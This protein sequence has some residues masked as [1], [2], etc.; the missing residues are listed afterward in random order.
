MVSKRVVIAKYKEEIAW[1]EELKE[2]GYEVLIY[3]KDTSLTH[4][5]EYEPK[6]D[7][8]IDLCNIGRESHTYLTHIVN[9]Y[10]D[11]RDVEVFFQGKI[12]DHVAYEKPSD[13]LKDCEKALFQSYASINKV[14][15]FNEQVYE[16]MK[17]IAPSHPH[18]DKAYPPEGT[19]EYI[20]FKE[21]Y[22]HLSYPTQPYIFKPFALF[23]VRKEVIHA[24]PKE[25]YEK[26]LEYF[27]PEADNFMGMDK[28]DFI[29][30]IGY[31]FE[32]FW[33][34]IFTLPLTSIYGSESI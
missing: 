28:E 6:K 11:L 14:G 33:Q 3:N 1:T 21:L 29:A 12:S 16:H 34:L 2:A 10:E 5:K 27:N 24:Y 15:C 4:Y 23:S 17:K 31:T 9:H 26:L 19:R 32:F 25:F 7:G 20:F 18:I 8:W 30:N 22:P 13:L